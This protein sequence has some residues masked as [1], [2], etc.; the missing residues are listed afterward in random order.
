VSGTPHQSRAVCESAW[1]EKSVHVFSLNI[2]V[3]HDNDSP[4][5][6]KSEALQC[7]IV[8][9]DWQSA[10][11]LAK[12]SKM[13]EQKIQ[14]IS[15][16]IAENLRQSSNFLE[17]ARIM[18]EYCDDVD[19]SVLDLIQGRHWKEVLRVVKHSFIRFSP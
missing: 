6:M 13:E 9:G 7:F 3:S 4:F 19:Q 5:S 10:F 2:G 17:S 14:E 18:I 11:Y 8:C 1:F 12:S 16:S 15:Y